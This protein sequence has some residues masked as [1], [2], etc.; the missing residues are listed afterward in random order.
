ME[1][2]AAAMDARTEA[3]LSGLIPVP[4]EEGGLG[5]AYAAATRT[6]L[7]TSSCGATLSPLA[8]ADV[9]SA[10]RSRGN[11]QLQRLG[12]Q[13]LG[14]LASERERD[15]SCAGA[16]ALQRVCAEGALPLLI[17]AATELVQRAAAAAAA[18][19]AIPP[20]VQADLA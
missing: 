19:R 15:P 17:E 18:G 10:L 3:L 20:D 5:A 6:L 16:A 13:M 11:P 4:L 12:V 14:A 8:P 7:G 1:P 9:C 2:L